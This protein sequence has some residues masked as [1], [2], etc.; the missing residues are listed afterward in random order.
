MLKPS[1]SSGSPLVEQWSHLPS[2]RMADPESNPKIST[3]RTTRDERRQ[4]TSCFL[5]LGLALC[6]LFPVLIVLYL[7]D[8]PHRSLREVVAAIIVIV[9]VKLVIM[10]YGVI[11][12][13]W[14]P[15]DEALGMPT[16]LFFV[17]LVAEA[18]VGIFAFTYWAY[19][20]SHPG[21]FVVDGGHEALTKVDALYF[22]LTTF[23]TTGFGDIHPASGSARGLVSAQVAMTFL[24]LALGF[25]VIIGRVMPR[26]IERDQAKRLRKQVEALQASRIPVEP[27]APADP[28][29]GGAELQPPSGGE[30]I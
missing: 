21:A 20:Q 18:I 29:R 30:K 4:V 2:R 6:L 10:G 8:T 9:V 11:T 5:T 12:S 17:L 16:F 13:L 1:H 23:T 25:T 3:W 14:G 19:S 24:S 7:F 27:A 15:D 26:M 22:S 28:G